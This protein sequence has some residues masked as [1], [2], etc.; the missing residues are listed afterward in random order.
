M[1]IREYRSSDYDQAMELW[2]SDPGIGLSEADER[3]AA[4]S[5]LARNPGCSFVCTD[6]KKVI[7]AVLSGH[8]GRRGYIYHLCVHPDYRRRGIAARLMDRTA[9]AMKEHGITRCHLFVYRDNEAGKEF[10]RAA[11]WQSRDDI[12]VFSVHLSGNSG[13][14]C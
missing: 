13:C 11:G 9:A 6:G 7:A 8:D 2:S 3:D 5:F 14:T 12:S 10:W 4:E 1:H